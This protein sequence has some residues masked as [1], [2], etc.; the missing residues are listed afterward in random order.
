[1]QGSLHKA[2]NPAIALHRCR[3]TELQRASPHL[4]H[5]NPQ[6]HTASPLNLR[7]SNTSRASIRTVCRDAA[8]PYF[9]NA[10]APDASEAASDGF[11]SAMTSFAGSTAVSA[12]Q[13]RPPYPDCASG[14]GSNRQNDARASVAGLDP[15]SQ[16]CV[17]FDPVEKIPL[18]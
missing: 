14:P 13:V 16:T 8:S 2:Q 3:Q 4:N 5:I 6:N 9:D 1:M 10:V 7:L 18:L 15:H 11:T 12:D 17:A